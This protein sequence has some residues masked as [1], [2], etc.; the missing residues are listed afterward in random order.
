MPD[1][2]ESDGLMVAFGGGSPST[3]RGDHDDHDAQHKACR[4]LADA[5]TALNRLDSDKDSA[6]YEA[7]VETMC[8]AL[9][10]FFEA[11]E[12]QPHDSANMK[13]ADAA[14]EEE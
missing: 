2:P 11:E 13:A 9:S 8:E 14:D 12:A 4:E 6:A 3:A 7:V 1:M 5:L 10:A